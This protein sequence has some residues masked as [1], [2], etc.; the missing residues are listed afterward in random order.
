MGKGTQQQ[1]TVTNA[2]PSQF[3][4]F[5]TALAQALQ[6]L[7]PTASGAQNQ[8]MGGFFSP[9]GALNQGQNFLASLLSGQLPDSMRASATQNLTDA[10]NALNSQLQQRGAFYGTPGLQMQ[11][12]L[13][14]DYG[15]NLNNQIF[16]AAGSAI[17][18][19]AS[20]YGAGSGLAGTPF[21]QSTGFLGGV[22]G[23]TTTPASFAP[24]PL[25]QILTSAIPFIK[26]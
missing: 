26:F 14:T 19:L 8:M 4:P 18:Q 17:P 9:G 7:L 22:K 6:G 15:N 11:A 16:S 21:G 25:T 13:A 23:T 10:Q 3:G 2:L 24:D 1:P 5:A 12:K 20:L